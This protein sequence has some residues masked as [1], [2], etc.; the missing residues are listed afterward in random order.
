ML[1]LLRSYDL[2]SVKKKFIILYIL[3]ITDILFTLILVNSGYF[4]EANLLLCNIINNPFLCTII[5]V[6]LPLFLLFFLYKSMQKANESQLILGKKF[7]HLGLLLY[8]IINTIHIIS[9]IVLSSIL[10]N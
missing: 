9:I 6:V 7:I 8:V 3:N 1:S 10:I 2:E 5:K 4:F